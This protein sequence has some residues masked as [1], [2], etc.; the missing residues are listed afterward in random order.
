MIKAILAC[1]DNGG[2]SR[3]GVMPWPKNTRDLKWF[4][5]ITTGQLVIMGRNTW[6]DTQMPSPLPNRINAVVTTRGRPDGADLSISGNLLETIPAIPHDGAKWIIGGADLVTQCLPIIDEFYLTRIIGD[7]DC[8]TFLPMN[9]IKTEFPHKTVVFGD[10][11]Y[12]VQ[13]LTRNA[14]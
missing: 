4:Q 8:D 9:K 7:Y 5:R 6:D 11:T 14:Q 12:S 1:D 10:E 2:V 13:I 3:N